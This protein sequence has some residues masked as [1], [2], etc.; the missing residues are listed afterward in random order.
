MTYHYAWNMC[1][2]TCGNTCGLC[3]MGHH[4]ISS[5][6]QRLNQT[7]SEQW[8][9]CRGPIDWGALSPGLSPLDFL[10]WRQLK[11]SMTWYYSKH[12]MP[13][14]NLSQTSATI[15]FWKYVEWEFFAHT[16]ESYELKKT[17]LRGLSPRTNY[18]DR[19][20]AACRR[21]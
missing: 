15:A 7:F 5:Q 3:I 12:G 17:K 2:F 4:L 6:C 13:V 20:T 10:L 19:A 14:I 8:I 1:L 11:T 21:S 18:T 9:G 16:S